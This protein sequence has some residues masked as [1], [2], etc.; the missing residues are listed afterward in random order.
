MSLRNQ[1]WLLS[2][3][4]PGHDDDE[5]NPSEPHFWIQDVPSAVVALSKISQRYIARISPTHAHSFH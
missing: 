4:K 1:I 5:R 2:K 3:A